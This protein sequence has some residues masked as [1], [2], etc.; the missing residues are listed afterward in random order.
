M[1]AARNRVFRFQHWHWE[2]LQQCWAWLTYDASH[3]PW[4]QWRAA[5]TL[6][7]LP[8]QLRALLS[9]SHCLEPCSAEQSRATRR[10]LTIGSWHGADWLGVPC[11]SQCTDPIGSCVFLCGQHL[12][13]W[14]CD[15]GSGLGLLF[16][17]LFLPTV[18]ID[19]GLWQ[20]IF[21]EYISSQQ[22]SFASTWAF[23]S[24]WRL[25]AWR[26]HDIWGIKAQQTATCSRWAA[27]AEMGT[28][29]A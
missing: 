29:E 8:G 3:S 10:L 9:G 20:N 4:H 22:S 6:E 17:S 12:R 23:T 15:N 14:A 5:E 7:I 28:T 19:I 26:Q 2:M 16:Y 24:Q 27:A 1:S 25:G 11:V 18:G 21:L 13:S